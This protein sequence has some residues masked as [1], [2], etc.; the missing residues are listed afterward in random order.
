MS[1]YIGVV[2]Q[3]LNADA[4]FII[5]E[6]RLKHFCSANKII[7]EPVKVG[8]LLSHISEDVYG[9]LRDLCFP[10]NPGLKTYEQLVKI[11]KQHFSSRVNTYRERIAFYSTTQ[12]RDETC[13]EWCV[14][15]VS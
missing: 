2:P 3:F 11:L 5:Y 8:L 9:T 10:I 7:E 12:L 13:N 15:M 14:L 6:E 4:D 1:T